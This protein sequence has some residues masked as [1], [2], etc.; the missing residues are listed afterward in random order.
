MDEHDPYGRE[1]GPIADVEEIVSGNFMFENFLDDVKKQCEVE[2]IDVTVPEILRTVLCE[3]EDILHKH[4][5]EGAR[6]LA[7]V[8]IDR[9]KFR[10]EVPA[11]QTMQDDL[12]RVIKDHGKK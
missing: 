1:L 9:F 7:D 10:R 2:N 11:A 8:A 12:D 6:L 5:G 3:I 4:T